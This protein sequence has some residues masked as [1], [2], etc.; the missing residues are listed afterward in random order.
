M[1]FS[2]SR[3]L[4]A[5]LGAVLISSCAV[6]GPFPSLAPREV[7]RN[8][9]LEEPVRT[10][11]V[12]ATDPELRSL[13]A[14]LL[15]QARKGEQDF[16]AA[17]GAA[18]R[19]AGRAGAAGSES[20]TVAQEAISRLEAARAETTRALAELDALVVARANQPTNAE[21]FEALT[22]AFAQ[23]QQIAQGQQGRLER[24]R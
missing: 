3:S 6:Q 13:A 12:V 7:E 22:G 11:P 4:S 2:R 15:A 8:V 21:D 1:A 10:P 5:A 23:A 16:N 24:L 17:H 18:V 14:E 19:A 20:W 9:S